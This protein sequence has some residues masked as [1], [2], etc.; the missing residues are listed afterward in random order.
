MKSSSGKV[1]EQSIS[2]ELTANI[3]R[4]VFPFTWNIGLTDLP[5]C[6]TLSRR[7]SRQRTVLPNDVMSKIECGQLYSKLFGSRHGTLQSHGLFALA[8]H[9]CASATVRTVLEA[10]CFRAVRAYVRPSVIVSRKFVNMI[11][12]YKLLEKFHQ[13]YN[14][15][16][17]GDKHELI[18]FRGR[19]SMVKNLVLG[20]FCHHNRILSD[21]SLKWIERVWAQWGGKVKSQ[22]RNQTKCICT[23]GF[24]S[25]SLY[26]STHWDDVSRKFDDRRR[27]WRCWPPD[28]IGVDLI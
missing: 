12:T 21:H 24:L 13:I 25:N 1:V 5:R 8:K 26:F 28:V 3:G 2:Y 20:P 18:R 16:A 23:D 17:T 10:S 7:W 14:F 15:G 22:G 11:C 4:K 27:R 19:T 6:C 9:L